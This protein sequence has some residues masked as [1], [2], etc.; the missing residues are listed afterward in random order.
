MPLQVVTVSSANS[1]TPN[2]TVFSFSGQCGTDT[3]NINAPGI[4]GVMNINFF[5]PVAQSLITKLGITPNSFVVFLL[6]NVGISLGNPTITSNCCY[7]GY[8]SSVG[9]QT[10]SVSEF[11]GRNHTLF[12]GV[13]DVSI[14][15]H[16]IG[17]WM[18]DP[19]LNQFHPC[20]APRVRL[21]GQ[22]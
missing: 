13:A 14:L 12:S 17:E 5:N 11:E 20:L 3:G 21:P 6:Y 10:Y 18:N 15:S 1:G 4:M 2:G 7:L 8:H 22:V 16:E 9:A 19:Q